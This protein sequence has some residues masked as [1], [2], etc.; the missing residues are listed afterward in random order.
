MGIMRNPDKAVKLW[1]PVA[2]LTVKPSRAEMKAKL[3][4]KAETVIL[5]QD[6]AQPQ[7]QSPR[8]S[9]PDAKCTTRTKKTKRS[10]RASDLKLSRNY[11]YG[12][13]RQ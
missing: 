2:N 9:I 4:A 10:A 12:V 7:F 1:N 6:S 13:H 5:A 8:A 11:Y 3:L